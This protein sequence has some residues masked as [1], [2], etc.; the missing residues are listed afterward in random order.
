[1]ADR[2]QPYDPYIPSGGANNA[3]AGG[4]GQN[5]NHRTAAL[6]AVGFDMHFRYERHCGAFLWLDGH[7]DTSNVLRRLNDIATA[8]ILPHNVFPG[9]YPSRF[10]TPSF[11]VVGLFLWQPKVSRHPT[12]VDKVSSTI[13][14]P[15][16][17]TFL[18]GA[19]HRDGPR[20]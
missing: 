15:Q 13:N 10:Q 18:K 2:E 11:I 8:I 5:G 7:C 17:I 1:M 3:N 19:Q 6:Q 14:T 20:D 4:A 9:P 12:T 16:R